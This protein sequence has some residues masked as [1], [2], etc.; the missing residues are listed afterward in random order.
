MG[1]ATLPLLNYK[2]VIEV[3]EDSL[4]KKGLSHQSEITGDPAKYGMDNMSDKK[5]QKPLSTPRQSV[6]KNGK[7]FT[8]C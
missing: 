5:N 3:K 6:D 1:G 8:I 7:K 4:L 2:E